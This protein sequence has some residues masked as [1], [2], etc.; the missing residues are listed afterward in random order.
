MGLQVSL[1][2]DHEVSLPCVGGRHRAEDAGVAA[3]NR[4]E[5]GD[6]DLRGSD[7]SGACA[8]VDWDSAPH[9]GVESGAALEGEEL[10]SAAQGVRD[11]AE[12]ILGSAPVGARILGC[13]EWKCYGRGLAEVH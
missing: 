11:F 8:Y 10:A 2:L 1:G 12:A 3:G 4:A 5:P 9:L 6:E 13:V 7:Q